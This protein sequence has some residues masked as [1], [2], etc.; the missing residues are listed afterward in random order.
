MQ[1]HSNNACQ[2]AVQTSK[3]ATSSV[4]Y[5]GIR[6]LTERLWSSE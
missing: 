2:A 4:T 5:K 3:T 1:F 6:N